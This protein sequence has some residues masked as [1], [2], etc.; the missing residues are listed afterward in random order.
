MFLD[1]VLYGFFGINT[2]ETKEY[3]VLYRRLHSGQEASEPSS[4][5]PF[6]LELPLY[7][8][9]VTRMIRM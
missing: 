9:N 4:E 2:R 3:L 8:K 7:W 6:L 1:F 5:A